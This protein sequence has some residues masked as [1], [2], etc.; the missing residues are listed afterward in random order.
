[1]IK[2][3]HTITVGTHNEFFGFRNLFIADNF[4]TYSFNS[5]DKFDQGLAQSYAYAFSATQNPQQAA[6]FDVNQIGFYVGDTWRVN[7]VLTL[8]TGMRI[9]VPMFPDKPTANPQSVA[10][11]GYATDVVPEG[12]QYSP[13]I[14]FNYAPRA[15]ATE[16]IRGGIGMFNG[17]TPYMWLSNQFGNTGIEFRR[18][19][20]AFS[21]A[22][23]IPFVA[24]PFNQ[25]KVIT[26][27]PNALTATNEIDLLDPDYRYPSL[28]RGNLAY[29]RELPWGL[30][31]TA[32][33]VFTN[34][35]QDIAYQNLNRV[36]CA[37][38]T[39]GCPSGGATLALDGRRILNRVNTTISEAIFLTNSGQG[40][41]YSTMF[42]LRR[43]FRNRWFAQG[44]YI[45]GKSESIM[46]GTSSQAASNWGNILVPNDPSFAPLATS[47]YD[48]RH[49]VNFSGSY[50]DPG[51]LGHHHNGVRRILRPVGPAVHA[52]VLRRCQRRRAHRRQ[53]Q[54]PALHSCFSERSGVHGR[55]LPGL[56][57]L[58]QR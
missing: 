28:L 24:D 55:H 5:V 9:D 33:L 19:S 23:N 32:E 1:M 54:R 53:F 45:Y 38:T 31:G 58:H 42:E 37:Q 2:G 57:Q 41:S 13:R 50:R 29:D 25:P 40:R 56:H 20:A 16:Q 47:T 27:A 44:S 15:D 6:R 39:L 11:F 22:N 8:T 21:A 30:V 52:A 26:G 3:K 36:P 4:G 49:R 34:D 43:P 48:I 35:I 18:I 12:A 10:L 17:R 51:G 14:G 46:D 7:P